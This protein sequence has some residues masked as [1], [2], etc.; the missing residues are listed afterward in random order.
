[1][2]KIKIGQKLG[3]GGH[4][5]TRGRSQGASEQKTF[6]FS[7]FYNISNELWARNLTGNFPNFQTN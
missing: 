4:N 3:L 2:A 6:F 1:M 7:S 5:W